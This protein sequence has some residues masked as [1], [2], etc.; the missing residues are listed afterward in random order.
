M[1]T[2]NYV[3]HPIRPLLPNYARQYDLV[4]KTV[5]VV[6]SCLEL[7]RGF[8]WHYG[9]HDTTN[10]VLLMLDIVLHDFVHDVQCFPSLYDKCL[11]Y[12]RSY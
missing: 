12:K 10:N 3:M 5:L 4:M 7:P 8:L 2:L 6:A 9:L 1:I 11:C